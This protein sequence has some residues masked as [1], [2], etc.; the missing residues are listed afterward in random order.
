MGDESKVGSSKEEACVVKGKE[1]SLNGGRG[2]I[3]SDV[4]HMTTVPIRGYVGCFLP[5]VVETESLRNLVDRLEC[6]LPLP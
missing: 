4:L 5:L 3:S 2:G 6:R 1:S